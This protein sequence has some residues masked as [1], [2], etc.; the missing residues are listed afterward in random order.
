MYGIFV[1]LLQVF[2]FFFF[3]VR[4]A[5]APNAISGRWCD[6]F[7]CDVMSLTYT[8]NCE[9]DRSQTESKGRASGKKKNKIGNE[10]TK[11]WKQ[12]K[13]GMENH[14]KTK[15]KKKWTR[16]A[17]I[18]VSF[19]CHLL[20]LFQ[21][22]RHRSGEHGNGMYYITVEPAHTLFTSLFAC[23]A[24][25]MRRATVCVFLSLSLSL[26]LSA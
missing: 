21:I 23:S 15:K 25:D 7:S 3:T 19:S 2:R 8:V 6:S 10:M 1:G 13:Y 12:Q 4:R 22:D 14:K 18:T 17:P 11:K 24:R 9:I 20:Y 5:V 26:S 16:C